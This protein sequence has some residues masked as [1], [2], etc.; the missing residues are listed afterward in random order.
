M[1]R[2]ERVFQCLQCNSL[3]IPSLRMAS[4]KLRVNPTRHTPRDV[5]NHQIRKD[6]G[7]ISSLAFT[8]KYTIGLINGNKFITDKGKRETILREY[9]LFSKRDRK[10][11]SVVF[12]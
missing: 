2:P 3:F 1:N 8:E 10:D 12:Q 11:S 5:C 4:W 9:D 6:Y 7:S